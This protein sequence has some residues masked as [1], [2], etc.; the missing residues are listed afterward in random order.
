MENETTEVTETTETINEPEK[1]I[2]PNNI[3][4]DQVLKALDTDIKN[5]EG[6]I[7]IKSKYIE[8]QTILLNNLKNELNILKENHKR[9]IKT[10]NIYSW[11]I[12]IPRALPKKKEPE[13]WTEYKE[14]FKIKKKDKKKEGIKWEKKREPIFDELVF[15][16]DNIPSKE[17]D[18]E[19]QNETNETIEN[20]GEE[21]N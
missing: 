1:R 14:K 10:K 11:I 21:N 17:L 5:I 9:K 16:S 8:E 7:E 15:E 2:D 18:N 19:D 6:L 20:E 3:T 12:E 13:K 4:D